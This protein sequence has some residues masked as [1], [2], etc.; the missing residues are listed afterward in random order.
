MFHEY[1]PEIPA[2]HLEAWFG[3]DPGTLDSLIPPTP[4]TPYR[5]C[6]GVF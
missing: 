6:V 2:G 5:E 3:S 4:V 1:N